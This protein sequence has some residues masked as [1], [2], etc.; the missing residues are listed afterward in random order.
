MQGITMTTESDAAATSLWPKCALRARE[1]PASCWYTIPCVYT[2]WWQ[3][4]G[5]RGIEQSSS[6]SCAQHPGQCEQTV[7]D[8]LSSWTKSNVDKSQQ[9]HHDMMVQLQKKRSTWCVKLVEHQRWTPHSRRHHIRW[10]KG[11]NLS[12]TSSADVTPHPWKLVRSG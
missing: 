4:R 8:M 5:G 9:S 11:V 6:Q 10:W 2:R 1:L 3:R 7:W 12:Y